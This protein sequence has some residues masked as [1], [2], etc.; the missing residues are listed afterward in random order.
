MLVYIYETSSDATFK[1][2]THVM[3]TNSF[4]KCIE[5]GTLYAYGSG[6]YISIVFVNILARL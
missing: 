3:S 5:F 2:G 6:I 1:P 4:I